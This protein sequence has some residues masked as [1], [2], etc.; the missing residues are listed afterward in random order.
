MQESTETADGVPLITL[1][2][3]AQ[4]RFLSLPSEWTIKRE[5]LFT[6]GMMEYSQLWRQ[7]ISVNR[8]YFFMK[9]RL[10]RS[11]VGTEQKPV[12]YTIS[13]IVNCL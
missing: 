2:R 4:N 6:T 5:F 7:T 11:L 12:S 13:Y 1:S 9:S 3:E 8:Y 10:F